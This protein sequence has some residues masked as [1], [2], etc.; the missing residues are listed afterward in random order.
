[1]KTVDKVLK[2]MELQL[3]QSRNKLQ[4]VLKNAMLMNTS[5]LL[6]EK[7][8]IVT[9]ILS[10][11]NIVRAVGKESSKMIAETEEKVYIRTG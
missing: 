3:V 5:A 4:C 2:L 7:K 8:T 9:I 10:M 1:M 11:I 6:V